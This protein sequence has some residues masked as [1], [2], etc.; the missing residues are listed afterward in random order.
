MKYVEFICLFAAFGFGLYWGARGWYHFL[1]RLSGRHDLP[2]RRRI[3]A[4]CYVLIVMPLVQIGFGVIWVYGIALI[5]PPKGPA[6]LSIP[7]AMLFAVLPAAHWWIS[8]WK[9]LAELGYGRQLRRS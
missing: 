4:A 3:A 1:V 8:R 6:M 2:V 9:R 5:H 7:L